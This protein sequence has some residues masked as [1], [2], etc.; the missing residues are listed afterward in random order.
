[1]TLAEAYRPTS[2]D[3]V[4]GQPTDEIKP[5]VNGASTPNFLFYGPPGTGKTTTARIIAHEVSGGEPFELNASDDRG[6]DAIRDR[7][8]RVSRNQTLGGGPPVIIL[9]ECDSMTPEAQQALRAPMEHHPGVFILT[10]NDI[11]PLHSAIR[12]RCYDRGVEFDPVPDDAMRRRLNAV[13]HDADLYVR[14]EEIDRIVS[15]AD[16]DLRMALTLLQREGD[17]GGR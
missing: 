13:A 14:Q 11:R 12:S 2:F 15:A 17:D 4:V 6:I 8:K 5:M 3:E 7:V 1:M 9:D 10:G 16:G